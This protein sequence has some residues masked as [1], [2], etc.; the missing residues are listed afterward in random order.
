MKNGDICELPT[1]DRFKYVVGETATFL[2]SMSKAKKW[3]TLA[4]MVVNGWLYR[5][6]R[7]N[8]AHPV[9]WGLTEWSTAHLTIVNEG[10][11]N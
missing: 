1:G 9:Y 8:M 6:Q 4:Y 10:K 3:D 5:L 7:K 2:F 11:E